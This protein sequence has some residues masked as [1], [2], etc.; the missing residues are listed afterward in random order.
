M[1][2]AVVYIRVSDPSQITNNSLE[3]QE[4]ACFAT[5]KRLDADIVEV[6]REEG[7]SAK[8]FTNRPELRKLLSFC[9]LKK[10]EV[11]YVIVYKLDRWSRDTEKGLQLLNYLAKYGVQ[12]VSVLEP[13][14]DDPFGRAMRTM[15]L[16]LAQLDNEMKSERVKDNMQTMFRNG[17]WCWKPP[18]GYKRPHATKELNKGKP[19]V[20]DNRIAPLITLLF[21]EAST[22]VYTLTQLTERLNTNG[23]KELYGKDAKVGLVSRIIQK[24]FYYGLMYAKKWNEYQQ[25]QHEPLID[26][27][28]W[29][30]ANHALY[31][32][33]GKY[34]HQDNENYPL[35]G[36]LK[37]S[38][39][40]RFLTS[41]NPTGKRK[42]HYYYERD[43]VR[44]PIKEAHDTFIELLKDIKPNQRVLKLFEHMVFNE[45]DSQINKAREAVNRY[46]SRIRRRKD[47][48]RRV[49]QSRAEGIYTVEEARA[50]AEE[51]RAD[52]AVLEVERADIK[53][54]EYDTEI[55]KNFTEHFL[56]NLDRFWNKVE[57]PIQQMLQQKI[58]PNGITITK[59]KEIRTPELSPL[60][61]LI[62]VLSEEDSSLVTPRGIE[63]RLPG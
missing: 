63:P 54:H 42:K 41:S 21:E 48:L 17:I 36:L 28:T 16:M 27:L 44:I 3:T 24:E 56:M 58:F 45:W 25:G 1:K 8:D 40:E 22:G 35:K 6:Y 31:G 39:S 57:L 51:I 60:F 15:S 11:D 13:H 29:K 20:L 7:L 50:E 37:A 49:S 26:E 53:L 55:V 32:K 18:V 14:R 19:P 12:L 61:E 9:S 5:A 62:K 43:G 52:I 34:Q 59:E 4:K 2:R 23:F 10:N 38:T 33:K 47:D 30:R 46:D